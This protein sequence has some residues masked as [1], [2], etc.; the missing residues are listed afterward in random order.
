MKQQIPISRATSILAVLW[1]IFFCLAL[2]MVGILFFSSAIRKESV[3]EILD[4]LSG[5]FAPYIG[6]IFAYYFA[7]QKKHDGRVKANIASF[8][9]AIISSLV[10]NTTVLC[11]LLPVMKT[12][13]SGDRFLHIDT[14]LRLT[15]DAAARLSWFTAPSIGYFFAKAAKTEASN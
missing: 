3:P 10:W 5:L 4:R 14:A 8:Y 12:T 1:L 15:G 13:A 9:L 7:S 2:A 11:L 6:V